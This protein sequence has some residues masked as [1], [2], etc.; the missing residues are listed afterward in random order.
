MGGRMNWDRVRR[1]NQSRRNGYEP[2][3]PLIAF[4]N[5]M[6]EKTDTPKNN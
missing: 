6:Y 5:T 3:W 2:F 1:E 4:E